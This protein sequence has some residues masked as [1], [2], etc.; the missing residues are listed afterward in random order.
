MKYS[1]FNLKIGDIITSQFHYF[2]IYK[3][4]NED[5]SFFYISCERIYPQGSKGYHFSDNDFTSGYVRKCT[6]KEV[7]KLYKLITFK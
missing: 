5:A 7:N 3:I 2:E 6:D 1:I 4:S